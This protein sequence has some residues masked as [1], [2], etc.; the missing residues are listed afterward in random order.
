LRP[1]IFVAPHK[2]DVA[3]DGNGELGEVGVADDRQTARPPIGP[4]FYGFA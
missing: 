2:G 4:S 3:F 1:S